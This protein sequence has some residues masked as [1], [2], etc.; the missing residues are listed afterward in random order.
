MQGLQICHIQPFD[1]RSMNRSAFQVAHPAKTP[2]LMAPTDP[3]LSWIRG[4]ERGVLSGRDIL[5]VLAMDCKS[6]ILD[7]VCCRARTL[8]PQPI[9]TLF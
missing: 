7:V 6:N 8:G 9:F 2:G 5:N 1:I 3:A 4:F